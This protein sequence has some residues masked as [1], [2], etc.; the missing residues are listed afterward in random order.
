MHGFDKRVVAL[1]CAMMLVATYMGSSGCRWR[2]ANCD[3]GEHCSFLR[4]DRDIV[5]S[6]A[7]QGKNS[8]NLPKGY[9][10]GQ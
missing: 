3:L 10:G 5:V 4:Q 6:V 1:A 8:Y 9:S 7:Q 2:D